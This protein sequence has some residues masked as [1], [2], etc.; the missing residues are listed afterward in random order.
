MAWKL[1]PFLTPQALF[2]LVF[3]IYFLI[4]RPPL[5][6]LTSPTARTNDLNE[7]YPACSK[8]RDVWS[9]SQVFKRGI[10]ALVITS[11]T[12]SAALPLCCFYSIWDHSEPVVL[13]ALSLGFFASS[14]V[15]ADLATEMTRRPE[16]NDSAGEASTVHHSHSQRLE[17]QDDSPVDEDEP[18]ER[19][20]LDGIVGPLPFPPGVTPSSG[21]SLVSDIA[22]MVL[23]LFLRYT[24]Y[25]TRGLAACAWLLLW[26]DLDAH[27]VVMYVVGFHHHLLA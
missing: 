23:A 6:C 16:T 9:I 27:R 18:S 24:V 25:A 21:S 22:R 8:P 1:S 15:V 10:S 4:L 26:G 17:E 12:L 13:T 19:V 20:R 7:A 3:P 11:I 2:F 5:R 14:H